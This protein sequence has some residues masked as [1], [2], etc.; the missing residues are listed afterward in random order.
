MVC[1]GRGVQEK[2]NHGEEKR[3]NSND[4]PELLS[5]IF[6]PDALVDGPD[7]NVTVAVEASPQGLDEQV[8]CRVLGHLYD[9]VAEDDR[10][11]RV[12][13]GRRNL[14]HHGQRYYI[15]TRAEGGFG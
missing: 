5:L 13:D 8:G 15:V 9:A 10:H 3:V 1:V 7:C 11:Q 14:V 2:T 6:V 12:D 4:G